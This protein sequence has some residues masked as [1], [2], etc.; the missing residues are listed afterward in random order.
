MAAI[1]QQLKDQVLNWEDKNLINYNGYVIRPSKG[2]RAQTPMQSMSW[3]GYDA[4]RISPQVTTK[5]GLK[6]RAVYG[7]S[8][9]PDYKRP[10]VKGKYHPIVEW[11]RQGYIK[12]TDTKGTK[13][14]NAGLSA[15]FIMSEVKS[16]LMMK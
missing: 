9:S 1:S 8:I 3:R 6:Y 11:H 12:A 14:I 15:T 13:I 7:A 2:T 16:K 10:M 4:M 5:Y